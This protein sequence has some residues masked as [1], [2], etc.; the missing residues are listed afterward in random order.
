MLKN[1]QEASLDVLCSN[2]SLLSATDF[3]N[4]NK[5]SEFLFN[6][7]TDYK[8]KE[9]LCSHTDISLIP[10]II[11]LPDEFFIQKV[12]F[13]SLDEIRE[14]FDT[15]RQLWQEFGD[16]SYDPDKEC[17]DVPWR[18]F[19]AGTSRYDI[20]HWFEERFDLPVS[21]LLYNFDDCEE[22]IR[23]YRK[24]KDIRLEKEKALMR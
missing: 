15:I 5:D 11:D 3:S 2:L 18:G 10:D 1:N 4:P 7:I 13:K 23:K 19:E 12:I 8:I 6:R 9:L 21:E 17:I 22:S 16:V 20:W 24:Y 14:D